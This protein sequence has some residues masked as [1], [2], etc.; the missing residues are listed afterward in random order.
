MALS[1]P[2]A[3]SSIRAMICMDTLASLGQ[4]EN[5]L[6]L[7]ALSVAKRGAL[8]LMGRDSGVRSV[9]SLVIRADGHLH[10]VQIGKKGGHKTLWDFG[11]I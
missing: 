5:V 9:Q 8:D 6:R 1:L 3:S 7:P 10:L 11:S 2:A 4:R